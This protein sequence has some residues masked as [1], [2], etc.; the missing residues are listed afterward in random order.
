METNNVNSSK[1]VSPKTKNGLR[2]IIKAELRRQGLDAD[3]NFIDTSKITDM[4]NLFYG[5]KI[6]NIKIDK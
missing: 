4:S 3:L 6:S 2:E 1:K 5:L